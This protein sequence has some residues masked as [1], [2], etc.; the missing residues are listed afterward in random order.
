[1]AQQH[2]Q[3]HG[4]V[5][6]TFAILKFFKILQFRPSGVVLLTG[7]AL[8]VPV[9]PGRH[10]RAD[11]RCGLPVPGAGTGGLRRQ[12][13]HHRT[14][15]ARSKTVIYGSA[16]TFDTRF[17]A[18]ALL[19]AAAMIAGTWLANRFLRTMSTA[20]FERYVLILLARMAGY[21]ILSRPRQQEPTRHEGIGPPATNSRRSEEREVHVGRD[22]TAVTASRT[23]RAPRRPRCTATRSGPDPAAPRAPSSPGGRVRAAVPQRDREQD[24]GEALGR[25]H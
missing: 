24:R 13:G 10:R 19:L 12:R 2:T 4:R 20:T 22:A 14:D 23:R 1:M 7:G 18:L 17:W 9:R 16:L 6:P 5:L 11:R 3:S 25:G 8:T 15:H 21:L